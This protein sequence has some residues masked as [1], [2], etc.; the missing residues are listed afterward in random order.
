LSNVERGRKR[1][2]SALVLAYERVLGDELRR[3]GV[4][5]AGAAAVVA[6]AAVAELIRHGFAAALNGTT[7]DEWD[8][9]VRGYGRDYMVDGAATVQQRLAGDLV[10]I[11][12]QLEKP[13]LWAAAARM[14]A[15]YG[16]TTADAPTAIQWYHTAALAADRSGDDDTRV[17]VRGRAALALAYEAAALPVASDLA[18]QA[19]AIADGRP[20]LGLLNA[21]MA[22]AHVLGAR[23]ESK[24]A[25]RADD[26][27][28]RVFDLVGSAEQ[29]S[30][31][32][33]PEWRMETFRSMLYARLG[34]PR[35]LT[36]Q[37]AADRTRPATLPRF[38]THIELHR[39]LMMVRSGDPSEGVAYARRAMD[40]LP[41]ERHSLSLRLMLAEVER[42]ARDLSH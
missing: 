27:G 33:I 28:R 7:L 26:A 3:R 25:M 13:G 5:T 6:P 41:P 38:A 39:G 19:L 10:V 9:T 16:K 30:D 37:E 32:A 18:D 23:G 40:A 4:L 1:I 35:G 8:E 17:W 20:S 12:Q 42:A 24:A 31:F 2:T 15:V 21:L 11:Q 22:R 29:V 36:A 14:L 34:H